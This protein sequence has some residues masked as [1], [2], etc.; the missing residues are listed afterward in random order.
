MDKNVLD[1]LTCQVS[2][3]PLYRNPL[4]SLCNPQTAKH[5][6]AITFISPAGYFIQPL[7]SDQT[8]D[9]KLQKG[10]SIEAFL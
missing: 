7:R 4:L 5:E 6:K 9:R 2:P 10:E 8:H 1:A 3:T